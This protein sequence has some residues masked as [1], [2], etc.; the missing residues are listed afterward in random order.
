MA[1]TISTVSLTNF[2]NSTVDSAALTT[3]NLTGTGGTVGVT[4]GAL[5]TPVVSSLAMNVTS[6]KAIGNIT[7]DADYTSLTINGSG[8]KSTI[9]DITTAGAT[10]VTFTGDGELVF[11]DQLGWANGNVNKHSRLHL[12]YSCRN[13]CDRKH[14]IW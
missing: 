10:A 3:L 5:T 7:L 1:N 2:G 11:T 14:G 6:A 9:A 8:T 12:Y 4:A 13:R